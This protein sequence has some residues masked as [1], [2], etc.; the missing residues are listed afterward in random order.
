MSTPAAEQTQRYVSSIQQMLTRGRQ[1]MREH[2]KADVRI[3]WNFAPEVGVIST[4]DGAVE[5]G[6]IKLYGDAGSLIDS[7]QP[8]DRSATV[9]MTRFVL[10][11]LE[12]EKQ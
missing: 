3:Q 5:K 7:I 12:D 2:P 4:F 8:K 1:W 9:I 11:A 10:D 6:L